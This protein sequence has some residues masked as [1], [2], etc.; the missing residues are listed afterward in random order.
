MNVRNVGYYSEINDLF[1]LTCN[2]CF[3]LYKEI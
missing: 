1:E 2:L 3:T